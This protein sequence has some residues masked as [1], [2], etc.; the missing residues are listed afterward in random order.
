MNNDIKRKPHKMRLMLNIFS[1]LC[2]IC[3]VAVEL[4]RYTMFYD[5]Y[6]H[7]P[8]GLIPLVT[9]QELRIITICFFKCLIKH[10]GN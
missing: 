3:G 2:I 4:Y 8:Q 10:K 9:Y 1:I 5:K 6:A 7:T